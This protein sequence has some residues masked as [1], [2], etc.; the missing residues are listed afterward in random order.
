MKVFILYYVHPT[1]DKSWAGKFL[2]VYSSQRTAAYAVERFQHL[3]EFNQYPKGFKV[4]SIE[5]DKD[6]D[7]NGSVW[8]PPPDLL[9]PPW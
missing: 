6:Y 4:E 7:H 1:A 3:P 5:V 8:I 2:G 9:P